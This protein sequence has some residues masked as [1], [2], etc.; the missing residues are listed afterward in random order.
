[1]RTKPW[2]LGAAGLVALLGA[3]QAYGAAQLSLNLPL[4]RTVY[5]TNE[6]I[7]LAVLRSATEAMGET[8]LALAL[9]GDNGSTLTFSFPLRAVA[10]GADGAARATEHLHLNAALLRPGA[11]KL[12]AAAYGAAAATN[13]EIYSHVRKTTFRLIDWGGSGNGADQVRCGE[14]GTGVNLMYGSYAGHDQSANIRGGIDYMRNCTMAGAHQ[15]D[16]RLECDWSD[17]SVLAGGNARVARQALK[18]RRCG[19]VIGVHFYDEP[20]LTWMKHPKTGVFTCHNIPSQDWAFQA[21]FGRE[22]LQYNDVKPEDPASRAAWDAWL[23]WKQVFMEAAW[24]GADFSLRYVNPRLLSATQSMYGW[25]AF[26]DGYYFNVVRPLPVMSG[27][28]GYD[29]YAGGY[30]APGFFFEMGRMRDFDKPVWFLPGWW[31]NVPSEIFRLEQYLTFMMGAQGVAVPPGV[32]T[33]CPGTLLQDEGVLESNRTMARLGTIF[34]TMPVTRPEVAVLYSMSQNVQAMLASKDYLNGQDFGG[35]IERLMQLFVAAKMSHIPIFPVVEEDILDG[36]V[37]ANHKALVLTGIETLDPK[38]AGALADWIRAGGKVILTDEC[39]V[40]IPGA[41]KLGAPVTTKIVEDAGREFSTGDQATRQKRGCSTRSALAYFRGGE[42]IAKAFAARCAELGI[43]PAAQI[44]EPQVFVSRHAQGD[45]EY[46]FLANATSDPEQVRQLYWN[47]VKAGQA[48]VTVP[49][50]GRPVY[51]ALRG[52]EAKE[53]AKA[54]GGLTAKLRFGP[55]E[56]RA[57]ARTARPVG[58]VQ[59]VEAAVGP[60]SFTRPGPPLGLSI[61]A[62]VTDAAGRTLAGAIP[63]A[64]QVT[65]PLGVRRYDLFRA[66]DCGA[67]RLELPLGVNDAAGTWTV[68]VRELLSGREGA[69]TFAFRGSSPCGALAGKTW[70]ASFFDQDYDNIYRF[71]RVHRNIALVTGAGDFNAAQARRLAENLKRW[72]I[73]AKLVPAADVKKKER[74]KEAW[75]TWVGAY[76]N[77]DFDMPEEAAVLLGSPEDNP[78]IKALDQGQFQ[79]L[80][81]VPVKDVFPGRSRGMLAWQIDAVAFWNYET[82]A[83]I[84]HDADGMAEAVGTLFEIASGYMPPTEWDLPAAAAVTPAAQAPGLLPE[85]KVLWEASLP[86]RAVTLAVDGSAVGALSLDGSVT[87]IGPD[88][89]V[90]SQKGGQ[91]EKALAA[92]REAMKP[93]PEPPLDAGMKDATKVAKYAAKGADAT[94]VAFW[95]GQLKVFDAQG[96]PLTRQTLPQDPV[97]LAWAG[98]KLVVALADG[99]V[100]A[101]SVK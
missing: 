69:A 76:D 80:P 52:A 58:G 81:Y 36:T 47:G 101:L 68:K 56:F 90:L 63:L 60:V 43:R 27:H 61:C 8:P 6:K 99:R 28:G 23:R 88:G 15:M 87:K 42:P 39:K 9:T 82:I 85:A 79:T 86:D 26:G 100:M 5:Q 97:G 77:P 74:P 91:E 57:F 53:F 70:R 51:D 11:Y 16:G 71:F 14:E 44:S 29:D 24:R 93:R 83:A 59:V 30:L 17:P 62:L 72:G 84:A 13:I 21:A 20:G 92:F 50:D 12:E 54:K 19:N 33:E 41:I 35:Q 37:A 34:T 45:V 94:A 98:D 96:K 73:S 75:P 67:L 66:T 31:E 10:P 55:G 22:A 2:M 38:V 46:L 95:G 32:R 78:L 18:D 65:D 40:A 4:S 48:D 89:Q 7:D 1:M 3:A 64:V 25:I 49:D